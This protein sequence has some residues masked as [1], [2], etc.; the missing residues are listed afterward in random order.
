L[1]PSSL[2]GRLRVTESRLQA[3]SP[4]TPAVL[5]SIAYVEAPTGDTPMES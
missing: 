2:V 1:S 3:G 4:S 5:W